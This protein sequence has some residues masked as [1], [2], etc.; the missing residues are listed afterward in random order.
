MPLTNFTDISKSII[1]WSHRNDLDLLVPDFIRLAEV[2]MYNNP[3]EPLQLKQLE[4][5][6]SGVTTIVDP[7]VNLPTNYASMRSSRLVITNSS[8][9]LEYRAPE[10]LNRLQTTG[11]PCFFTILGTKIELDRTP[12]EVLTV[13]LEY[14]S[15]DAPLT[16]LAPTNTVLT[17]HPTIYLYGALAQLFLHAEDDDQLIKYQTKFMSAIAGANKADK[18]GRFGPA[19]VMKVAGSTP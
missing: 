10:Q 7:F 11:R 13:E 15:V 17:N 2:E 3:Q 19:P 16:D 4:A 9:F 1:N 5:T 8:D 18:I 12:D 14:Y 6:F